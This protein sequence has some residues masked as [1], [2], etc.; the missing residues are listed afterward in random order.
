[1]VVWEHLRW[2]PKKAGVDGVPN[3]L[4]AEIIFGKDGGK[5]SLEFYE[6]WK[7]YE[8]VHL[9]DGVC[10]LGGEEVEEANGN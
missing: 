1:M 5:Q 2:C 9:R 7:R 8:G 6:W 3:V 4:E 10:E